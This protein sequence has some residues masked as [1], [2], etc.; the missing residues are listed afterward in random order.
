MQGIKAVIAESFER[1]HRS[2][3][4]GMGILPLQYLNSKDITYL[5]QVKMETF[6]LEIPVLIKPRQVLQL[7]V[8]WFHI[9]YIILYTF[10]FFFF[11]NYFYSSSWY[12]QFSIFIQHSNLDV[13]Q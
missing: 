12:L 7:Q 1:I 4:I 8:C 6:T 11:G 13:N 3:L 10:F 2:N 5:K 9:L